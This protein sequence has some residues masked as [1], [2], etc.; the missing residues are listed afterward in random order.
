M[1]YNLFTFEIAADF[2]K[3]YNNLLGLDVIENFNLRI[4]FDN[5]EITGELRPL[6]ELRHL[7]EHE[8]SVRLDWFEGGG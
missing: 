2:D 8:K 5:Q 1:Y 7:I 4:D 3:D 6:C